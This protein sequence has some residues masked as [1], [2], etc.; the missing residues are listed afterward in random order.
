MSRFLRYLARALQALIVLVAIVVAAGTIYVRTESFGRLLRNEVNRFT[1]ATF[2]GQ[3]LIG[4][5]DAS[6]SGGLTIHDL[7][8]EYHGGGIL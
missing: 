7:R 3:L 5:V 1:A 4:Q 6:I 2:R 8:I